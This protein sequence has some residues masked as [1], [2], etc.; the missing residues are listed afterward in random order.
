M[1]D[2][3]KKK[4]FTIAESLI[5][6]AVIGLVSVLTIATSVNVDTIKRKQTTVVSQ[7]FYST[8]IT[9]LQNVLINNSVNSDLRNLEDENGD[10]L[11]DAVDLRNY[12]VKYL[13]GEPIDCSEILISTE[14]IKD[15][16]NSSLDPQCAFFVPKIKAAFVYDNTCSLN[17]LT[18]EYLS[19]DDK[20]AQI[21]NTENNEDESQEGNGSPN[22][23]E[24]LLP[25]SDTR[26]VSNAC[27]YI[28]Y[29][30]INSEGIFTKDTFIVPFGITRVK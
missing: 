7:D 25:S 19:K 26:T 3:K 22:A 8:I 12:F 24:G 14:G 30:Y 5:V 11:V 4:A 21:E 13:D 27:G 17:V 16:I 15:Y 28:L 20:Y 18:K 6:L 1:F 10:T 29:S 2:F 9:T 23:E